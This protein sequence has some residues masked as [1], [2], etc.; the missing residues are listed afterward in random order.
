MGYL[1]PVSA[2]KRLLHIKLCPH[3]TG[4]VWRRGLNVSQD[5]S[6]SFSSCPCT[7]LC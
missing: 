7:G 6:W 2:I 3:P 5:H 1:H 4:W